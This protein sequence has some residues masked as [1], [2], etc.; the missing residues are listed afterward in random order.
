MDKTRLTTLPVVEHLPLH[1]IKVSSW[2]YARR[3]KRVGGKPKVVFSYPLGTAQEIY[4]RAKNA[5]PDLDNLTFGTFD[6]GKPA[7]LLAMAAELKFFE[8]VSKSTDT[9]IANDF[10]T[11]QFMFMII[12]GRAHGPLSKSATGEWFQ[13][14]FLNL[15]WTP[16]Q[17]L[18]CQNF[19]NH[20]NRLTDDVIDKISED[21]ARRLI[22]LGVKPTTIFWDPTNFSTCMD[23]WDTDGLVQPGKAKDMRY[24]KNIVGMGL[25]TD[26]NGIPVLHEVAPGNESDVTL[27]SR[28]IDRLTKRLTDM[29][30]PIKDMVLVMDR[31]NNSPENLESILDRMHVIGGLKKNQFPDLLE[32]P[33][34]EFSFL[35]R[36]E[37]D[38][39]IKGYRTTR[40]V[41]GR[42]MTVI[43]TFNKGTKKRQERTWAVNRRK[44]NEGMK[45]LEI[46]YGRKEGKG[47]RMTLKG[48][49]GAIHDLVKKQYRSVVQFEVDQDARRLTW[50]INQKKEKTMKRAFG[51]SIIFT[52]LSDWSMKRIVKTYHGKYVIEDDFKW[53][54][55]KILL[56]IAPIYHHSNSE[57]RIKVHMFLCVIGMIFLRYMAR[58]LKKLGASPRELWDELE[59]LRVILVQDKKTEKLRFA[60][61]QMS[62][63]QA[64]TFNM[65]D[66]GRYLPKA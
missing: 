22:E 44:I 7:A 9:P 6:F 14:T 37:K 15:M 1:I 47:R 38:H 8:I 59:R 26:E 33:R 40:E 19:L 5:T 11:A 60:L 32:I 45:E 61:E 50:E 27:F 20:M 53:L 16:R 23:Q 64:K 56:S 2:Y 54:H 25:A 58:R 55:Q 30:L 66:L 57:E 42:P 12:A 17:E 4:A 52:D 65:L 35:Y 34:K 51:K 29:R 49:T 31:G 18:S 10:S 63:V 24:D 41:E 36:N 39:I 62:I 28:I 46:S 13:K 3:T 21:M 48:L 43:V